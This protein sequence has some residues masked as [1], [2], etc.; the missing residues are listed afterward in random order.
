MI[1]RPL[2]TT[3]IG[4]LGIASEADENEGGKGQEHADPRG[5]NGLVLGLQ[6]DNFPE[7][8]VNA[9]EVEGDFGS[10]EKGGEAEEG[11]RE[12]DEDDAE[13]GDHQALK[14]AL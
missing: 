14:V 4:L 2:D 6:K 1:I 3:E 11:E 9:A 5:P 8:S 12:V 7:G 10:D 13:D